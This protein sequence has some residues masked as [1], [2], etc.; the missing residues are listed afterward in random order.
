MSCPDTTSNTATLAA[1]V[2][3]TA[4]ME[5]TDTATTAA[6]F[7][8]NT[9]CGSINGR[10]IGGEERAGASSFIK[11]HMHTVPSN[12][13]ATNKHPAGSNAAHVICPVAPLSSTL[14]QRIVVAF[15]KSS[16]PSEC[17]VTNQGPLS[18]RIKHSLA[19][20]GFGGIVKA[21]TGVAGVIH[22]CNV[23]SAAALT[24]MSSGS[25]AT[26]CVVTTASVEESIVTALV[27]RL[28]K[29]MLRLSCALA[30]HVSPINAQAVGVDV[31]RCANRLAT[32]PLALLL[33]GDDVAV[34][35]AVTASLWR[36]QLSWPSDC[37]AA[38]V[39]P[40]MCSH[41]KGWLAAIK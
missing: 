17:A 37:P 19:V 34:A 32:H 28:M 3:K 40:W 26:T 41:D 33:F 4:L 24:N 22:C 11:C 35:G 7:L 14:A 5:S 13:P 1:S 2:H 39:D 25:M 18:V 15:H 6:K 23:P 8:A 10:L 27:V 21:S 31:D 38:I 12:V 16:E 20:F 9:Q 30:T 36:N 29:R